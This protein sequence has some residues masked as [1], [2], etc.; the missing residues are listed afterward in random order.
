VIDEILPEPLGGAQHD[1]Q[2]MS[3][4]IRDAVV[5]HLDELDPLS[6]DDLLKAR[7]EKFRVM[8]PFEE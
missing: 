1:P 2:A 5:R 8:G 4:T 3:T 7:Y 6:V